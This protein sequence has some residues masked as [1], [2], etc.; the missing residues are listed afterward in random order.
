MGSKKRRDA[1]A[2]AAAEAE[3]ESAAKRRVLYDVAGN[4]LKPIASVA[5]KRAAA[6]AVE[7][8]VPEESSASRGPSAT[9]PIVTPAPVPGEEGTYYPG[10]GEPR[11]GERTDF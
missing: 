10:V 2:V 1:E 11:V 7:K 6:W 5:G 8:L 9:S 3:A 4:F